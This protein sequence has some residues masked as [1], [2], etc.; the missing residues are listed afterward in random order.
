[1]SKSRRKGPKR[2]GRRE[3]GEGDKEE[4]EEE[5]ECSLCPLVVLKTLPSKLWQQLWHPV[6]TI[7]H[8]SFKIRA[9]SERM[10]RW[11]GPLILFVKTED[12]C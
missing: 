12:I 6:N 8:E 7:R 10:D 9:A 5:K 3:G 1:M 11:I 4:Q 2:G